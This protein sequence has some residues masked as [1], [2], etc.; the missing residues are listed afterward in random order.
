MGGPKTG[1]KGGTDAGNK[2]S[3]T[4]SVPYTKEKADAAIKK[5][6]SD[7]F[8]ERTSAQKQ[9]QGMGPQ[10]LPHLERLREGTSNY[11]LYTRASLTI[12]SINKNTPGFD[13]KSKFT[14]KYDHQKATDLIKDLNSEDPVARAKAERKL[15]SMGTEVIPSLQKAFDSADKAEPRNAEVARSTTRLIGSIGRQ[16]EHELMKPYSK[17]ASDVEKTFA[18]AGVGIARNKDLSIDGNTVGPTMVLN[19]PKGTFT[20]AERKAFE[21]LIKE[22]DKL[23]D[24]ATF[25][26]M[27][28]EAKK[29]NSTRYPDLAILGLTTGT[30]L[31]YARGLSAS[32]D[33]KDTAK[34]L[35]LV[36]EHMAKN[37][38]ATPG[39][40]LT[41][42]AA[43]LGAHKD[44]KFM[45]EFENR[46][47]DGTLLT[48]MA[49]GYAR[50]RK[51]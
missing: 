19:N 37:P 27:H 18:K 31:V 14:T 11:D 26:K 5:F 15:F 43:R 47:G 45:K 33:P 7:N 20:N 3:Q 12:D 6:T 17:L 46:G 36:K 44:P 28:D 25:R 34:G 38:K 10:A 50:K 23:G 41:D 30:R 29:N 39:F 16:A 1:P 9:L 13:D 22:G 51:K 24:N 40:M 49:E 32:N 2:E 35:D 8:H 42:V 4:F 21:Q 48:A